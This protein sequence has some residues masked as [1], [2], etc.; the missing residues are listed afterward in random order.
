MRFVELKHGEVLQGKRAGKHWFV[1]RFIG[2]EF[3]WKYPH[4]VVWS[5]SHL[6]VWWYWRN[7]VL[8]EKKERLVIPESAT[9]ELTS[10][11]IY[12][13]GKGIEERVLQRA[14]EPPSDPVA[15]FWIAWPIFKNNNFHFDRKGRKT[16]AAEALRK[17]I[18]DREQP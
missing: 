14:N 6:S 8:W 2:F 1:A 9:G 18:R 11:Q 5:H 12:D 16:R 15:P 17:R 13:I 7:I 4:S 10:K 3:Q